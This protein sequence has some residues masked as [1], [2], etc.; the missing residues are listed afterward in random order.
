VRDID[1][2]IRE[3]E[4]AVRLFNGSHV[5]IFGADNPNALRGMYLDGVVLDEYADMKPQLWGEVIRPTLS[6]RKGWAVF[7]GTP[8]GRN[9]FCRL[10]EEALTDQYWFSLM[11]KA[12]QTGILPASELESAKRGMTEDQ[13]QQEYECSFEAAIQGAIY[14]K[15]LSKALEQGRITRVPYDASALVNTAW[16]IGKGDATSIWFFQHV[17]AEVRIIDFYE[18]SGEYAPHYLELLKSKPYHYDTCWLPHDA[19]HERIT[20]LSFAEVV[21]NAGLRAEVLPQLGLEEGINA[22]RMLMSRCVFDRQKCEKGL[23]A[24]RA[25]RWAYNERMGELKSTPVH[26]W[27]SHAADAWRYLAQAGQTPTMGPALKLPSLSQ[28]YPEWDRRMRRAGS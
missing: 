13:Y 17:G 10:Y 28:L 15:E 18:A 11:L 3:S 1:D 25:Y 9:E 23:E 14:A 21:R 16:D 6:D 22:A 2:D 5:R 19:A 20:G 26:D 7:I 24:L 8:R 27:S 4:L 12:S